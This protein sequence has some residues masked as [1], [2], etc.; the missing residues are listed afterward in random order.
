MYRFNEENVILRMTDITKRFPGTLALDHVRL[1][2]EKGKVHVLLGENG[3][4][5]STLVKVVCG[6]YSL[7]EGTEWYDGKEVNFS[8]VKESMAAGIGMIHQE[9]SL[10]PERTVAQNIFA[11]HEPMKRKGIIDIKKMIS[12]S[13]AILDRLEKRDTLVCYVT[14]SFFT[15]HGAGRFDTE[16]AAIA[17]E[18]GLYDRTNAPNEFQGNFRYGWF[19]LP[20]FMASV[21]RDKKYIK[22][23]EKLAVAVTHLDMT[24]GMILCPSGKLLPEDIAYM[25]IADTLFKVSGE[26]AGDVVC[27]N[28]TA[29]ALS[30]K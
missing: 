17:E 11:G 25:T 9:L 29:K 8:N 1:T 30:R 26:T 19:D 13:Q 10:L 4:G 18:Y 5:K 16:S 22:K 28:V 27:Q 20:E 7:D 21:A 14:R 2:C 12:D 23:D 15:R 6:L 24:G 3:A